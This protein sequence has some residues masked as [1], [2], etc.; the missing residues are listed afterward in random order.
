[1]ASAL[2][3]LRTPGAVGALADYLAWDEDRGLARKAVWGLAK[4]PGPEAERA[5][6]LLLDDPDEHMRA[7]A[8][9]RQSRRNQ[10][11]AGHRSWAPDPAP[12]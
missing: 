9:K 12:G 4:P 3:G 7:Y 11:L 1:M 8:A 6:R 2:D 10:S 5:L